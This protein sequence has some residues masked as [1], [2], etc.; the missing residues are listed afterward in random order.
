LLRLPDIEFIGISVDGKTRWSAGSV[1]SKRKLEAEVPLI[2]ERNREGGGQ[3]RHLYF[4]DRDRR[5][6]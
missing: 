4:G 2:R 6:R 1:R 3:H 5:F